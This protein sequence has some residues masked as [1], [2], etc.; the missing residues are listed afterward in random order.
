[1]KKLVFKA[2]KNKKK[3]NLLVRHA[4]KLK[5]PFLSMKSVY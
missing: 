1:M 5:I 2:K 3:E 4:N